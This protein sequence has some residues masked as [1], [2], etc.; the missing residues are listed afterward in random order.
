MANDVRRN[1]AKRSVFIWCIL[2]ACLCGSAFAQFTTV[3]GTVTDPNGVAYAFGTVAPVIVASTTPT[4]TSTGGPYFQPTQA[5]GLDINGKFTVRLADNTQLSPA[6]TKWQFTVCSGIGT[7]LWA[8]GTGP[9]CFSLA[10]PITISGSTQDISTQLNAVAVALTHSFS[11]TGCGTGTTGTLM[12]FAT[13]TTCGN[14][15]FVDGGSTGVTGSIPSTGTFNVNTGSTT[16]GQLLLNGSG[17][18]GLNK[19]YLG[20]IP[21]SQIGGGTSLSY[22][23]FQAAV[24]QCKAL[25]SLSTAPFLNLQSAN[26]GSFTS[27]SI[28]DGNTSGICGIP[29]GSGSATTCPGG[30]PSVTGIEFRV[31]TGS[32][33]AF[34][35]VTGTASPQFAIFAGGVQTL[36]VLFSALGTCNSAA[37]GTQSPITDSTT[38]TWGA[39]ITGSG[40]NHVLAYCDGTNWTVAAK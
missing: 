29:T 23:F 18:A 14:S 36:A 2:L 17:V 12:E 16:G 7:V 33:F 21:F 34:R 3:T 26:S 37:E 11:G 28:G 38:A 31:A 22:C 35:D 39:T 5:T 24:F 25:S 13:S 15:P 19:A 20:S 6:S 10:A 1:T 8:W 27:W 32:V 4:F 40:A 9:V 30:G